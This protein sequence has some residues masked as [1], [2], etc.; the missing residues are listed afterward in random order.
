MSEHA[1]YSPSG[2]KKWMLCPGSIALES[3]EPD[4]CNDY[5]DEGTAAHQLGS[6]C[7]TAKQ[8]PLAFLGRIL[9]VVNGVYWP[10][11]DAPLPARLK[12]HGHED[13]RRSFTV[14]DDMVA[15]V[16]TYV[17]RVREYAHG[18]E[19][20]VEERVPIGHVTGEED[21]SGTS[22]AIIIADDGD[23]LQVHDLKYG[24]GVK[25]YAANNPQGMLYLLGSLHKFEPVFGTPKRFRFVIHQPRLD[26]LDEW[27]CSY[28]ELMAFRQQAQIAAADAATA[29]KHRENW[30]GKDNS[31]LTPG[32]HCKTCFCKARAT[33][34]ALSQFVSDTL[35]AEFEVLAAVADPARPGI[36]T[37]DLAALVPVDL[38]TLG[39]KFAVT[40][41]IEDWCKQVRARAESALFESHNSV[42]AQTVL[43]IKLVQGKKGNRKW[44]DDS[45]I[46]ALLKKM[47][48]KT[49]EIFNLS[50]KSPTII[51]KALK[52][53]PKRL[54]KVEPLI[55][56]AEG[57]PSVAL[58]SDSRPALVLKPTADDFQVL[59]PDDGSDLV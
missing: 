9:E 29:F 38:K 13:I 32:E 54:V 6:M 18:N 5:T 21:A 25:V 16:N 41:L 23:E 55:V 44:K 31:Y 48:L 46:I 42:E 43:G 58:L 36:V 28:E 19:I 26:H 33:C 14:D 30:M 39:V 52:D 56:Q 59:P 7:L 57:R 2:A 20:L 15:Y 51:T 10:G 49:E 3:T 27:D 50:V 47:R 11:G 1:K 37:K 24:M 35:D 45:E 8:H 40:D 17:Q 12:G 4:D 34:P 22:D 53:T